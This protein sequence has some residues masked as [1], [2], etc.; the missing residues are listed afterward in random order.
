MTGPASS[1]C[2]GSPALAGRCEGRDQGKGQRLP[3]LGANTASHG[4]FILGCSLSQ[5]KPP[6]VSLALGDLGS[7]APPIWGQA[8]SPDIPARL[9]NQC[10]NWPERWGQDDPRPLG[11][12]GTPSPLGPQLLGRP[13]EEGGHDGPPAHVPQMGH[14]LSTAVLQRR[15]VPHS[16][17]QGGD[18]PDRATS[19]RPQGPWRPGLRGESHPQDHRAGS[20]SA[21]A[22]QES[23]HSSGATQHA[24]QDRAGG[25]LG[26]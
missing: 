17:E 9:Q 10:G 3:G 18:T 22:A 20:G 5:G 23:K 12:M 16:Q 8:V 21:N 26:G 11:P 6:C 2:Q 19:A 24:G 13:P 4:L 7:K 14:P 15:E 25:G 1:P